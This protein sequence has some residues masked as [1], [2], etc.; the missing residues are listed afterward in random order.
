MIDSKKILPCVLF[1]IFTSRVIG[2]VPDTS[3]VK[4]DSTIVT[5]KPPAGQIEGDIQYEALVIDN[6][7]TE[8][9]TILLGNAKVVYLDMELRAAKITVDWENE[10]MTA[11][12]VLDSVWIKTE[13]G[14]SV[15]KE[16][17]TGLPEFTEAGDLITGE[18]MVY[19]FNT[20]KGRVLRGRTKYEDGYYL[21][22]ALKMIKPKVLN[23]ADGQYTT[24]D[25][26][27][28]PHFHFRSNKMKIMVND[29]VIAKPIILYLG[30]IPV[31][32]LPFIYFPIEKGRHSGIVLPR[33]G[34]SSYEGRY[35]RE[36]GYYWAASDY[37]DLK[38]TLSYFEKSGVLFR[39]DLN[40]Q[41]RYSMRGSL[42]GSWTR[43]D[44]QYSGETQ[45]LW[46]LTIQIG[47][48]SCRER[49]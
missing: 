49:V 29:K 3:A 26:T 1:W 4:V 12:G 9:K 37:W 41:V 21:G 33:Y 18:V 39:G 35:L 30:N 20:R 27:E 23:V 22:N 42:S 28:R 40:Y 32:A 2:Q 44:F 15:K 16:Q 11:E 46:D 19:N 10:L 7:M 43:K 8:K 34:V 31:L 45:R 36:F 47:R 5:V 14:D 6:L 13:D 25:R 24:C 17:L 38:A 48:A